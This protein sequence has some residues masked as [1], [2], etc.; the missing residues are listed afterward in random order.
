MEM[1]VYGRLFYPTHWR[2]AKRSGLW[3]GQMAVIL[4]VT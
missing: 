1:G 3:L 4:T 2:E